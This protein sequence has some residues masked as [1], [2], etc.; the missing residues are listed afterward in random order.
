MYQ[1]SVEE[2]RMR[3]PIPYKLFAKLCNV[4]FGGDEYICTADRTPYG[5][6]PQMKFQELTI[7]GMTCGHCVMH[8]KRELAKLAGVTI[9]DVQ[10]GK[11]RV[12]YDE[13]KAG[14]EDFAR[15]I[16]E[17]GYKLVV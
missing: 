17:A 16:D 7:E 14:A 12:Q 2:T 11:A 4:F 3:T 1:L 6:G 9:E 13:T 10:I 15:A 5:K 8:V